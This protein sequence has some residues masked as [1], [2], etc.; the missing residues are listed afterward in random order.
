M[1][2]V[3]QLYTQCTKVVGTVMEEKCVFLST[4]SCIY[5]ISVVDLSI[6]NNIFILYA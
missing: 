5:A 2:Y 1:L 4:M 6:N 3:Y